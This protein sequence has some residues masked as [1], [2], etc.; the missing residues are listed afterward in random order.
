MTKSEALTLLDCNVTQLAKKLG[1]T[2]NAVSQWDEAEIPL[3]RKYQILD[4]ANGKEPLR[5]SQKA[6]ATQ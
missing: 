1:I 6:T 3:V 2:S 4:I 5:E